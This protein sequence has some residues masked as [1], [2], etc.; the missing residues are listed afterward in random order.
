[1]IVPKY[2]EDL[3]VLHKNTMPN[4]AYYIPASVRMDGNLEERE[5]SDRFVQLSGE[6]RFRY[7]DSIYEA[8]EEFWQEGFRTAGF[9]TVTVPD[10]W[11]N[12]GYD[13]HQYTNTRY[14][15]PMDPPYVP[16]E[17]PCG[18][19]V[20]T[21]TYY[22]DTE[23]PKAF[24]NFEGV[25][26]CFY[27]WVN[28]RFAGYSQVS[29][30]TSEFD[31]TDLLRDGENTLA[32][33]VLKWCDGSYLEDQDKFRMSG[34]FRDVYILKR[35]QNHVKNFRILTRING[36]ISITSDNDGCEYELW[37]KGNIIGREKGCYAEFKIDNPTLW[38]AENPYLYTLMIRCG[39]EYIAQQVGIR[40]ITTNGRMI[41]LNGKKL[42]LKGVN[43]HDSDPKTGSTISIAQAE[44]D[45]RMM[46]ESNINAIRTSHYP[47][48]PW[49]T[50]LCD[51][52][53]F[54][55]IGESDI[56]AH[57][58][59]RIKGGYDQSLCGLI[60][61]DKQF[62]DAILDRVQRNVI[63]DINRTSILFWS[64]GNEAGYGENF[65]NAGR[66]VKEYDPSRLT[67]YE[68]S[69]HETGG[70]KNDTSMLD[71]YSRMYD[72]P[73]QIDDYFADDNNTKPYILCEYIHAMGNGPGGI[74]AYSERMDKY[75]GFVGGFVWEWCDHAIYKGEQ[76]GRGIYYYGG[77]HGE[78]P[79]DGNFCMDGLVY[80]DRRPHTGLYEYKH[81]IRPVKAVGSGDKITLKNTLDFTNG[82]D[83]LVLKITPYRK[84]YAG[85]S[86]HMDMP[87]I[88]P[89]E[90]ATIDMPKDCDS[91]LLEYI[92]KND[93]PLVHAG[94]SMGYDMI[95]I[96]IP[97][98]AAEKKYGKLSLEDR[99]CDIK[100]TGDDFSYTYCKLTGAFSRLESR[101]KACIESG[102]MWNIW[103][104][105]TDNDKFIRYD[106]ERYHYNHMYA[107]C[108]E[109][110]AEC[111]TEGSMQK[112]VIHSKITISS[113]SMPWILMLDANW[114]I[115]GN[116]VICLDLHAEKNREVPFLPRFGIRMFL[117]RTFE[118]IRYF[119]FGPYESYEDKCEASYRGMFEAHITQLHEDYVRPQENGSHKG[120]VFAQVSS[121][122]TAL[123]LYGQ[124]FS[125]NFSQYTQEEL[126]EKK[127]NF[128]LEKASMNILCVDYRQNGIGTNSCG[129]RPAEDFLL[130]KDFQWHMEFDFA[131]IK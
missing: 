9:D 32:V 66:W 69:V 68:G 25:D 108:K 92:L 130:D 17:N 42:R 122:E 54:Y 3:S 13:R 36:T 62:E 34:I 10:V 119:G 5:R 7:Y 48:A 1:M 95:E 33:L 37:D 16:H 20:R 11:Q 125:F 47:N 104:A 15:F 43:R 73:K 65:E 72:S 76:N 109:T 26:S 60:A 35:D 59:V 18:E 84:G 44:T 97:T 70:H 80:P 53:G 45:L 111:V 88:P 93:I 49:F 51:K 21:F 100:I 4:R 113:M 127:H 91:V 87:P 90:T 129:P 75:Q 124:D 23:A 57:G 28:G 63:R 83:Y 128:E 117:D 8:K 101:G 126:T 112:C 85:Q 74:E 79:N 99:E 61:Q 107:R 115:Y 110:K 22:K 29:H 114:S 64:L 78:F 86:F 89:G 30:S 50:E 38:S 27:V 131:Q 105:P 71:V 56:E 98:A 94:T 82:A 39:Q 102:M 81:A 14:P 41:L 118:N 40:E 46:K 77:D 116:S 24:L 55:V 123:K 103:R 52:Y 121:G 19:Y 67:H 96:T 6:W 58:C 12:Y 120:C 31:V 106:W 2:Y